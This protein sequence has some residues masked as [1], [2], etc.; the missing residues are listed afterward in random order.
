MFFVLKS[1]SS[2]FFA[3]FFQ[4]NK[5]YQT[6]MRTVLTALLITLALHMLQLIFISGNFYFSFVSYSLA[7]ITKPKN[8]VKIR[9]NCNTYLGLVC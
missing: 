6:D 9:I 7:Y 3:F 8:Q 5:E 4:Y 1:F 2:R